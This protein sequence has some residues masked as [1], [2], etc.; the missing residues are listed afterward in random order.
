MASRSAL[1][2]AGLSRSI[3]SLEDLVGIANRGLMKLK[4]SAD[5]LVDGGV[6]C[7]IDKDGKR[8]ITNVRDLTGW[9][10]SQFVALHNEA[11]KNHQSG[12]EYLAFHH[13]WIGGGHM[14]F[15]AIRATK[16]RYTA[17]CVHPEI[18]ST[19]DSSLQSPD[20]DKVSEFLA[21]RAKRVSELAWQPSG[22]TE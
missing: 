22:E 9:L 6:D 4:F 15:G 2:A 16:S 14:P 5:G 19:L 1:P 10:R 17:F 11:E 21:I 3:S 12:E 18:H 13:I 20:V 7:S 8:E